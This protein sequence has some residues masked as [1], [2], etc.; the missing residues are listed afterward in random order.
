MGVSALKVSRISNAWFPLN[1]TGIVKSCD[2]NWHQH[3]VER[4]ITV[5]NENLTEIASNLQPKRYLSS[6]SYKPLRSELKLPWIARL[7]DPFT[8]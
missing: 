7:Y 1:R 8:I 6:D 5:E 4:L 3:I 2:S